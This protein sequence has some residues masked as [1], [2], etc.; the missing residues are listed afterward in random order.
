[1]VADHREGIDFPNFLI[2]ATGRAEAFC[3]QVFKG[4]EPDFGV[5]Q[6]F[7]QFHLES[8]AITPSHWRGFRASSRAMKTL[9]LFRHGKSGW[10]T[11]VSR[12]YDRP[13]N[14][15]GV[16]GSRL[17]GAHFREEN[18][19]FDHIVSS[20]AVRCTETLDALWEGYGQILHPNWDR[21]VYLASGASLLDVVHDLPDGASHVLMCGHNPGLEDLILMLVPDVAGDPLRDEVEEKLPTAA[22]AELQFDVEHWADIANGSARFNRFVR[23]RDLDPSLGPGMD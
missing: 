8:P 10:D 23:P 3:M 21:R 6:G 12:D 5:G 4:L 1:M 20:P 16:T 9:I 11:A 22:V 18:W 15:R 7:D 17:I 2:L 19:Q 14:P 13:I